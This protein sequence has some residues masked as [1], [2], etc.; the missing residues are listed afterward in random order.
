[1]VCGFLELL[2]QS[3]VEDIQGEG[4]SLF[5]PFTFESSA[6]QRYTLLLPF[7]RTERGSFVQ[8]FTATTNGE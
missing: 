4:L 1:M 5:Q 3:R 2:L 6:Q 7:R 8:Q